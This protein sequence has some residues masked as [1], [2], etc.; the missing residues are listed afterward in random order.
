MLLITHAKDSPLSFMP[1]F[2]LFFVPIGRVR[3][4]NLFELEAAILLTISAHL[5]AFTFF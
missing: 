3:R 4:L 1:E 2:A 5:L